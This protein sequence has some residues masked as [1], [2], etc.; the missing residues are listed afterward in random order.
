MSFYFIGSPD[1]ENP[2]RW[3]YNTSVKSTSAIL[4]ALRRAGF[5]AEIVQTTESITP[6]L[7]ELDIAKRG[8]TREQVEAICAA[9]DPGPKAARPPPARKTPRF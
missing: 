9:A 8:A 7:N 5:R 1:P 3:T 4:K 6:Y 2:H